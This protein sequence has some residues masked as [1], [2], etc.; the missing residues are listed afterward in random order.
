M[1]FYIDIYNPKQLIAKENIT[2]F[3]VGYST[4]TGFRTPYQN[5]TYKKNNTLSISRLVVKKSRVYSCIDKG[6]HSYNSIQK[7]FDMIELTDRKR[8]I[9]LFEIPIGSK[10]YIS[11]VTNEYVSNSIK[12]IRVI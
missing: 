7:A 1:C 2:C 5:F 10:Y 12:F 8:R 3:K 9:G 11:E 6:F 4:R